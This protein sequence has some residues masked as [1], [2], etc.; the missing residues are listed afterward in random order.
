MP[1]KAKFS[2]E[3][4]ISAALEIVKRDGEGA[5]TARRL[6]EE[7]GCSSRPIFT[8]FNNMDEVANEVVAAATKIYRKLED[9]GLNAENP[10]KGSGAGYIRFAAEYPKLF[11]MLFMKE[12]KALIKDNVLEELD[13]YYGKILSS[14]KSTYEVNENAAKEIYLHM[15][16][17]SHGIASLLATNVCL[18]TEEQI[19]EMLG[20]AGAGIIGKYLKD[21]KNDNS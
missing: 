11:I 10:F 12:R 1:P 21:L 19:S 14:I 7:L 17:Y 20:T 9:E 6:G 13:G 3:Q 5:L 16:V 15:W 4:I 8:V 18:F 2:R